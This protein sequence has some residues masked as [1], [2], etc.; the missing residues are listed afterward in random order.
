VTAKARGI[1]ALLRRARPV[2]LPEAAADR[3]AFA[4]RNADPAN[5]H[6]LL[7]VKPHDQLGDLLVAAP[8]I[9]ALRARYPGARVV[10]VT[11]V[12]LE[13][14][15]RRL[16]GV[17][18]VWSVPR[19]GDGV[20]VVRFVRDVRR[21]RPDLAFVLNSVSRS[22]TA[23]AIAAWSAPRLVIG[24][25]VVGAGPGVPGALAHA[26]GAGGRGAP[27]PVYD[28]DVP[29]ARE[30]TH[31]VDRVLD[32]V[33]WTGA[34]DPGPARLTLSEAE[35]VAGRAAWCE[36][37]APRVGFHPAAANALK[38]WPVESFIELA[39]R[40]AAGVGAT[41][42]VFDTPKESGPA[43]ALQDGLARRGVRAAWWPAGPLD[44]LVGPCV[45]LDLM[46]CNDSGILHVAAALGVPTVSFHSLGRPEEWAPRGAHAVA[47]HAERI[48]EIGVDAAEAAA[49]RL[50]GALAR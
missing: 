1:G 10:L 26:G 29:V 45:A 9:A 3:A 36:A 31:Q 35:R 4:A 7:V 28:L 16:P 30:S 14:L 38:C 18:A 41:P 2:A 39:A 34:T 44:A 19:A 43:R 15:A 21:L 5:V 6:T 12:Y 23:D 33:R 8:A 32:L 20:Q 13:P 37:P 48:E 50:L 49:R 11:R 47:L 24:R 22:G 27:D 25:S 46:V 42:V 40:L 17:D